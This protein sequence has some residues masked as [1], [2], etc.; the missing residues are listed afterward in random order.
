MVQRQVFDRATAL[1]ANDV[2]APAELGEAVGQAASKSVGGVAPQ[3][4]LVAVGHVFLVNK[5]FDG[6]VFWIVGVAQQEAWNCQADVAGVF[7]LA[8]ALPFDELR[9]FEVIL[10]VL[11]VRQPREAFQAEELAGR[12]RR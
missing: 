1:W 11:E 12:P 4:M 9:A 3:V 8:E 5:G 10:Q 6:V 7:L 2:R